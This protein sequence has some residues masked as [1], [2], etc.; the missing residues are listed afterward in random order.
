MKRTSFV[1]CLMFLLLPVLC[2]QPK[3]NAAPDAAKAVPLKGIEVLLIAGG[4]WGA[5]QF[6]I[7][8]TRNC[9][10][11]PSRDEVAR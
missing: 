6:Y 7:K 11:V 9:R 5:R 3:Q 10:S 4:L 8:S 1:V 2:A